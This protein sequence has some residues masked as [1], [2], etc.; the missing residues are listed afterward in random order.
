MPNSARLDITDEMQAG[1]SAILDTSRELQLGPE[2][3]RIDRMLFANN[4]G[5]IDAH[6]GNSFPTNDDLSFVGHI[7]QTIEYRSRDISASIPAI[8]SDENVNIPSPRAGDAM[9]GS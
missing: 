3:T 4:R 5:G 7:P 1:R 8:Q 9:L 2:P 6:S